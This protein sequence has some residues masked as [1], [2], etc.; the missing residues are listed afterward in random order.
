MTYFLISGDIHDTTTEKLRLCIG[1]ALTIENIKPDLE[2]VYIENDIFSLYF[3]EY[4][5]YVDPR[6]KPLAED[7]SLFLGFCNKLQDS[8]KNIWS[9]PSEAVIQKNV[10]NTNY[11]GRKRDF[12][13]SSSYEGSFEDVKKFVIGIA[14]SLYKRNIKFEF[15]LS[16]NSDTNDN[17]CWVIRY[18]DYYCGNSGTFIDFQKEQI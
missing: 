16:E 6:P 5:S 14:H 15:E 9:K 1:E 2:E 3:F 17:P 4:G 13:S 18:P 7:T 10:L 12:L 11:L 8:L